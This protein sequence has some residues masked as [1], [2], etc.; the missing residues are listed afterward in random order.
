MEK[1]KG[2]REKGK[3]KRGKGGKGKRGRKGKG[4]GIEKEKG[5][6]AADLIHLLSELF[7]Q[8]FFFSVKNLFKLRTLLLV[9]TKVIF[10]RQF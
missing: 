2:E 4:G 10:L 1:G 3:G 7:P 9:C 5:E 8:L 6:K